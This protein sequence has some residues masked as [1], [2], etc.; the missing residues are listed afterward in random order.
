MDN[1]KKCGINNRE[2][3]ENGMLSGACFLVMIAIGI[4]GLAISLFLQ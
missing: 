3:Y 4:I 2:D 1:W